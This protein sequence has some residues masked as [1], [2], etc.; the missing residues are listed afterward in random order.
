MTTT[1]NYWSDEQLDI[2][3]A[4]EPLI[5]VKALAGTGKTST[6]LERIK[7]QQKQGNQISLVTS[8]AR[9]SVNNLPLRMAHAGIK[10]PPFSSTLHKLAFDEVRRY[11]E[12]HGISVPYLGTGED[13]AKSVLHERT[14]AIEPTDREVEEFNQWRQLKIAGSDFPFRPSGRLTLE[15]LDTVIDLYEEEKRKRNY[16]DFEDVIELSLDSIQPFP[17]E[18]IVDEAQDLSP[19]LFEFLESITG[20][21]QTIFLDPN[22]NIYGFSGVNPQAGLDMPGYKNYPL[23]ESFRSSQAVCDF[24]NQLIDGDQKL[25]TNISGGS[26][27]WLDLNLSPEKQAEF[28]FQNYLSPGDAVISRKK[29]YIGSLIENINPKYRHRYEVNQFALGTERLWNLGTVHWSKG[30]EFENVYI[31]GMTPNGLSDYPIDEEKRILYVAATRA[32]TNLNICYFGT[33]TGLNKPWGLK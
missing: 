22:Q 21:R 31:L 7:E 6:L 33:D 32:K 14:K 26:V 17:G 19:L 5:R 20:E 12:S 2:I 15:E 13:V 24:A 16:I 8:F 10:N 29:K 18:V 23:T 25:R 3:H 4:Q 30:H 11:S 9:T 1:P 27:Q 28:I